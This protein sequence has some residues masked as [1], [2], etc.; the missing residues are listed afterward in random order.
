MTG[1]QTRKDKDGIKMRTLLWHPFFIQRFHVFPNI[2]KKV[3]PFF[4]IIDMKGN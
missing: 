2:K 3:N 1:I 4:V